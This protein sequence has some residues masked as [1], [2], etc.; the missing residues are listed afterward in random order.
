MVPD[1]TPPAIPVALPIVPIAVL[2]LLHAPPDGVAVKVV[3]PPTHNIVAAAIE[4]IVLGFT[5]TTAITEHPLLEKLIVE[6]P[7]ARP[8]TPPIAFTVAV[9][10]ELLLHTPNDVESL[11]DVTSP[12]QTLSVPFIP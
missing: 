3:V 4:V 7:V 9:E 8:V 12:K 11:N 2:K 1:A 5:V 10:L 6:V